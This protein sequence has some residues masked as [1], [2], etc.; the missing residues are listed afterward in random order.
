[1]DILDLEM[2]G[3]QWLENSRIFR[4]M[5]VGE[6]GEITILSTIHLLE[7]TVYKK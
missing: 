2:R 1:M 6:D 5:V 7:Y 4:S 3:V